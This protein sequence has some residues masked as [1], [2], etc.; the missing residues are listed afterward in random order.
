MVT[1]DEF[2]KVIKKLYEKNIV[3]RFN[4]IACPECESELI[5]TNINECLASNPP[6]LHV[7]CSRCNWSGYRL[8]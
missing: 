2:N 3:E 7:R 5:D 6:Q 8:I 1:L 4:N